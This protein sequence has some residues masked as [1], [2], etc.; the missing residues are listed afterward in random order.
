MSWIISAIRQLRQEELGERAW[1]KPQL[2]TSVNM[3]ES[4]KV[5]GGGYSLADAFRREE[6][7]RILFGWTVKQ[8]RRMS[9]QMLVEER[10]R[11]RV[12]DSKPAPGLDRTGQTYLLSERC[13][14]WRIG[15]VDVKH[16]RDRHIVPVSRR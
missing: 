11:V 13:K 14:V 9:L 15:E 3:L 10:Q 6:D 16:P 1:D 7:F 4:P 8:R 2:Y 12:D 5:N